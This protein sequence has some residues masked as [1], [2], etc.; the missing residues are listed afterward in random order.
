MI[1]VA[2]LKFDREIIDDNEAD[3]LH[4]LGWARSSF[5]KEKPK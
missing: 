4:I 5:E 2:I 3:A 1:R